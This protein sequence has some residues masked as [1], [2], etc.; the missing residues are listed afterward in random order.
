MVGDDDDVELP[1]SPDARC[2]LEVRKRVPVLRKGLETADPFDLA[3][4][5]APSTVRNLHWLPL[6]REGR[7]GRKKIHAPDRVVSAKT[8]EIDPLLHPA[9]VAKLLGASLSCLVKSRLTGTAAVHQDW[10]RGSVRD[11]GGAR[12]HP[13]PATQ[14]HE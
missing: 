6:Q 1:P 3:R 10:A 13:E 7:F 9:Q 12:V 14:L 11:V 4:V 2:K 5:D 8:N